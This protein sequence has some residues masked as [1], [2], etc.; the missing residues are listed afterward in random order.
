MNIFNGSLRDANYDGRGVSRGASIKGS[1]YA[2][3]FNDAITIVSNG[4]GHRWRG[5]PIRCLNV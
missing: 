3:L 1:T 2:L 5:L 4:L